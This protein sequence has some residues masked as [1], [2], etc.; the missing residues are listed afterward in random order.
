M[1]Q[2]LK[3]VVRHPATIIVSVLTG[4]SSLTWLPVDPGI[5]GALGATLWAHAGTLFSAGS[6]LAFFTRMDLGPQL[7]WLR[8]VAFG[9]GATGAILYA[10]KLLDRFLDDFNDRLQ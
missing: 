4:L 10:A 9:I 7:A 2:R 3:E 8:P 5:L 1:K 6:A